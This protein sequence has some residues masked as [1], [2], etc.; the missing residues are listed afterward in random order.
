[1]PPSQHAKENGNSLGTET[2]SKQERARE[3][4]LKDEEDA[5]LDY[6][7]PIHWWFVSTLFPLIA[8]TFGP[9]ASAFNIM[10]L[11]VEWRTKISP[12]STESEGTHIPDPTWNVVVN[13]IS[14]ALAVIANL[15]LLAQMTD[16]M[17]YSISAPITI[18]GWYIS[19]FLLIGLVSACPA[20]MPLPTNDPLFAYSQAFYYAIFAGAIYLILSIMLSVTAGGVW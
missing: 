11:A 5:I 14:L 4:R 8:G 7:S 6:N 16:R 10:A 18:V 2:V 9:M 1:M 17:R 3:Y 12:T 20:H 13:A 19:S 15:A